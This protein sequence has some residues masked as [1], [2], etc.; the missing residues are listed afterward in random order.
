MAL[1]LR[2]KKR[3]SSDDPEEFR[4]T[5]GE[6]LDELRSRIMRVAGV[7]ILFAIAGWF[8]AMPL[9]DYLTAVTR[10]SIPKWLNYQEVFGSFTHPFMLQLRMAFVIGLACALPYAIWE[11]WLFVR[12]GL[13]PNERR[14]VKI[15]FPVSFLLFLFGCT[16]GW[17]MV[18]PTIVWF[19]SFF[20]EFKGA[21][22]YQEPGT[23]VF[24]L[25][26]LVLAFGVGFQLPIVTFFLTK[27]GII[28]A[29]T[30]F[31][32]WRHSTV[33]IFVL[34]MILTPSGDPFTMLAMAVPLTVLFF[35]SV[36]AVKWTTKDGNRDSLEH[37]LNN[38]D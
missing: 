22:L 9:Y 14:P 24:L 19:C 15:L 26:K 4:A 1:A 18:P 10:N 36:L 11:L 38:L 2:P 32:S 12:P 37:E 33:A 25:I 30:L 17:L 6:H 13:K 5:L 35:G 27:I 7:L 28:S 29:D 8:I 3:N 23:L 34:A 20:K 21:V 16:I 31:R